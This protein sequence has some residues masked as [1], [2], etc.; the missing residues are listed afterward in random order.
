MA[1]DPALSAAVLALLA[2]VVVIA[3]V[4]SVLKV[5]KRVIQVGLIVLILTGAGILQ[6]PADTPVVGGIAD[7]IQS[8]LTGMIPGT[9]ALSDDTNVADTRNATASLTDRLTALL[10]ADD[11]D[12]ES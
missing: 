3:V 10:S 8:S 6:V 12:P 9:A 11:T 7:G 4:R 1:L 5:T 2:V